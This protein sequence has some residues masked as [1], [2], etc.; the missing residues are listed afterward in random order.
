MAQASCAARELSRCGAMGYQHRGHRFRN[1]LKWHLKCESGVACLGGL[2]LPPLFN[3]LSRILDLALLHSRRGG[4]FSGKSAGVGGVSSG[5]VIP[6]QQG[7]A[8][9]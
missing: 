3:A 9:H 2:P 5:V 1:L 6:P 4:I 7:F 8:Q